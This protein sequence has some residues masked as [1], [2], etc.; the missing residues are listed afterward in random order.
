MISRFVMPAECFLLHHVPS[1]LVF[2]FVA[3]SNRNLNTV[4]LSNFFGKRDW[5]SRCWENLCA[6]LCFSPVVNYCR[7]KCVTSAEFEWYRA[8]LA[9]LKIEVATWK[10]NYSGFAQEYQERKVWTTIT[11]RY[12]IWF[13]VMIWVDYLVYFDFVRVYARNFVRVR[14][15]DKNSSPL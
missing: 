13:D 3:V 7:A 12:L 11:W 5:R 14:Q 8:V 6:V 1:C 2:S 4:Y 15:R 9:V 10:S